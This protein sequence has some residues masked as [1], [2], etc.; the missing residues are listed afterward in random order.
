ME[1]TKEQHQE[2]WALRNRL[3]ELGQPIIIPAR[4]Q[5]LPETAGEPERQEIILRPLFVGGTR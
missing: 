5:K 2:I 3:L 1:Y 4:E